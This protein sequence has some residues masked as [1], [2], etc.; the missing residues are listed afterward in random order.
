M[1]AADLIVVAVLVTEAA[2]RAGMVGLEDSAAACGGAASLVLVGAAAD[3][4]RMGAV[5]RA[6]ATD[7]AAEG[8]ATAAPGRLC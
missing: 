4:E 3:C 2:A 6:T 7:P 5:S 8:A 1:N